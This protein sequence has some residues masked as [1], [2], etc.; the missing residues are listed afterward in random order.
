MMRS[1]YPTIALASALLLSVA[2][3]SALAETQ[4]QK[5]HPRRTEVN[6]RLNRQDHRINKERREGEISGAQAHA[7]HSQD[8]Q[9]RAQERSMASQHGGHITKPEQRTLNQEE[10]TVSHEIGK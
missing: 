8:A 2:T 5:E 4:W 7:L 3:R 6:R 10:N 9:I 1:L